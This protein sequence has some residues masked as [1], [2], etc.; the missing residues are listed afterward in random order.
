[1]PGSS[2]NPTGFAVA[3][4]ATAVLAAEP[5][6]VEEGD[7]EDTI[8]VMV[9][10]VKALPGLT[11]ER[12]DIL[13]SVIR[14]E[15]GRAPRL[16]ENKRRHAEAHVKAYLRTLMEEMGGY[17]DE[18]FK[19]ARETLRWRLGNYIR[20]R[21]ITEEERRDALNLFGMLPDAV[22]QLVDEAYR[23]VPQNIRRG[24]VDGVMSQ[25]E[26]DS[27]NMA[28]YFF[29]RRLY[30]VEEGLTAGNI[31]QRLTRTETLTD[32]R[33]RF[34]RIAPLLADNKITK[35]SKALLVK[36]YVSRESQLIMLAIVRMLSSAF[37]LRKAGQ[38]D[39]YRRR[40]PELIAAQGRMAKEIHKTMEEQRAKRASLKSHRALV[41]DLLEGSEIRIF[42]GIV[43]LK[44]DRV[45][46]SLLE[47]SGTLESS[48]AEKQP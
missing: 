28:N 48:T 34:A 24:I 39:A 40:P 11:P 46:P 1:M 37:D 45:P 6:S 2:L 47:G 20:L 7:N 25:L 42:G 22:R 29:P 44:G 19:I 26:K 12:K 23:G 9:E 5:P 21:P 3:L 38:A 33:G 10:A 41:N 13:V 27:P 35:R 31:A 16:A 17:T 18:Q 43:Y 36:S 32:S 4:L 15:L 30:L 14:T 8:S